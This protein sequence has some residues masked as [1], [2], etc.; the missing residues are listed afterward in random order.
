M[1]RI[2]FF[3]FNDTATTEIYTLSLHDA[4]PIW[5]VLRPHGRV[6]EAARELCQRGAG[7]LVRGQAAHDLHHLHQR[8]RVEE[9]KAGK[10]LRVLERRGQRG[11]GQGRGIAGDEGPGRN[12]GLQ[13]A[14]QRLLGI[15]AL[16]DGLYHQVAVLE[17]IETVH[18]R[19]PGL[20]ICGLLTCYF[21][22]LLQRV[23]QPKQLL[24]RLCG[25]T[26]TASCNSTLAPAWAANWAMP[27]P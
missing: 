7:G 1:S 22:F 27:C 20:A 5:R 14:Q 23:P 17:G 24:L 18:Y 21:L 26:G 3:F 8:C 16:D 25:S 2:F 15:H 11:D 12:D 19:Q 10:A 13:L 4:L 9:V 6:A